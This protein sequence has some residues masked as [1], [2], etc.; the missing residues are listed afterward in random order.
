MEIATFGDLQG[1]D[2]CMASAQFTSLVG[3]QL[4]SAVAD[5]VDVAEQ[6]CHDVKEK[7]EGARSETETRFCSESGEF[8][9][10]TVDTPVKAS[11]E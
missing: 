6:I 11:A 1:I 4:A 10:V 2:K 8:F 7:A 5:V 3:K 9:S